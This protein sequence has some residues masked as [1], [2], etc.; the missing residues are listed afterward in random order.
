MRSDNLKILRIARCQISDEGIESVGKLKNLQE[1]N[2]NGCA[3]VSSAALGST[4]QRLPKLE[5][6]DAS[7]CPGIL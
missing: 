1:L 7:Y 3:N 2:L 4:L 6:L 5:V